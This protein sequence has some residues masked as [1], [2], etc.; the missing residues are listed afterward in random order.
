MDTTSPL[1][2]RVPGPSAILVAATHSGA[3]KT[4]A[5]VVVCSALRRRGLRVQ[6]FKLGPD[7]IDP[8]YLGEACGRRSINLD[9]WMMGEEG[10]R[11]SYS[12]WAAAADISVIESMGALYDGADGTERDS[13][14]QVAKLLGLPVVVVIDVYGMTRTAAAILSGLLGFDPEIE[15]AGVILNRVGSERHA[16]M[17]MTGLPPD[18]RRLVLGA[19][20]ADPD[21]EIAERHLGLVTPDENEA[22]QGKREDAWR[23]GGKWLDIERLGQIAAADSG[24]DGTTDRLPA[25]KNSKPVA[26]L[27]IARD[28]AFCFYYEENL[29]LLCEAGFELAPFRP[30]IDPS[31]PP[32]TDA[33]YIGGGYPESF[34][35]ELAANR[36]LATELRERAQAGMPLYAECG[37]LLYLARSLVGFNGD[38]HE[39]S[40]VLPLDLAM[41][42]EF[43]AIRYVETRSLVGSPLGEAGTIARGHEFHQSRIVS[44]EIEPN[45]YEVTETDRGTYRDGYL[46]RGVIASYV[47]LH[48]ASSPKLAVNLLQAALAARPC[49]HA[50]AGR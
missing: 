17:V 5:T 23:H 46:C 20:P 47:H 50:A 13:A 33:V 49:V 38:R 1:S 11:R 43:L 19:I 15:I 30:T 36:S 18:L 31:L 29:T 14:A 26:K 22:S 6:P 40:G 32:D 34:A 16:E 39:M 42:R 21:L 44:A 45:L 2:Q 28:R 24:S 37:G 41:D 12:R 9:I 4:T 8:A 35:A 7:F 48:F 25:R 3:G 27:A 10:V